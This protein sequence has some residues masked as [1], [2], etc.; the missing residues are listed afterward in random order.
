MTDADT[1]IEKGAGRLEELSARLGSENGLKARLREELADDAAFL[2]KLKPS[3]IA[4]R[5]HGEMPA[6]RGLGGGPSPPQARV[7]ADA[8]GS[9]AES[10]R[11]PAAGGG[12]GDGPSALVVIAAAF[13]VGY[14]LAKIV[15]WRGHAHPRL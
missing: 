13:A 3:A 11:K 8:A 4:A 7:R 1:L 10:S 15:D 12:G 5:A 14:V 2:R 9:L 6:D